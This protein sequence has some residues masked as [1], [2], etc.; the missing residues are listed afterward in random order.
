MEPVEVL[1]QWDKSFGSVHSHILLYQRIH[2]KIFTLLNWR[3][4]INGWSALK[5][6]INCI[7]WVVLLALSVRDLGTWLTCTSFRGQCMGHSK[8][9]S[10]LLIQLA[11]FIIKINFLP[12]CWSCYP[13]V[14]STALALLRPFFGFWSRWLINVCCDTFTQCCHLLPNSD[15]FEPIL[16]GLVC[17]Y[18][19]WHM[20]ESTKPFHH[21]CQF[22]TSSLTNYYSLNYGH[23]FVR[24]NVQKSSRSNQQN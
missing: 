3:G 10:K 11:W 5:G 7:A 13:T 15:V 21:L 23:I 2:I 8:W 22:N 18:F 12:L 20:F 14:E 17:R 1:Q 4:I 9:F 6:S 16:H 19:F 24:I